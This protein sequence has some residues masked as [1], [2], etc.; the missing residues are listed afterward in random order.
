MEKPFMIPMSLLGREGGFGS[1]KLVSSA[2]W[3]IVGGPLAEA[4]LL[5]LCLVVWFPS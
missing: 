5:L 1:A 2:V 3:P 4:F